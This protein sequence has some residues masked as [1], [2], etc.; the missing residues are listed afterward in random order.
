MKKKLLIEA[1]SSSAGGSLVH[2]KNILNNFERQNF[3]NEIDVLIPKKS[4]KFMPK[5]KNINYIYNSFLEKN[6]VLRIIWQVFYLNILIKFKNYNCIFVTGSSHFLFSKNVVT[7]SQNLLP[8]SENE[9]KKYFFSLFYLKLKLLKITQIISFKLSKGIIFLHKYSKNEILKFVKTT[10]AK[11]EVIAHSVDLKKKT[12]NKINHKKFRFIYISNIDYYKNQD[13]IIET[14]ADL[15]EKNPILSNK[16][17]VEFYGNYYRPALKKMNYKIS[18]LGKNKKNFRYFGLLPREKIYKYKKDFTTFSL[19][20]SS[21][22]N[23][24]VSLIESMAIGIPI[25]CVNLQPMKSVLGNSAFYYKHNSKESFQS[26]VLN[27]I[28]KNNSYSKKV[29][30]ALKKSKKYNTISMAIKTFNFLK[31]M[32][33]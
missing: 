31:A 8:F 24:S 2:L 15:F 16:I 25:L 32:S 23:F 27:M 28:K 14:L 11:I 30:I 12:I 19:F 9:V 18:L 4:I 26:Q 20:S 22:E 17:Y 29:K 5:K 21:C 7:I 10:K 13:F 33:N 1:I 3:F 6:L